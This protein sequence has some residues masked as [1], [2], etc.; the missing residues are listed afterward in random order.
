M[1]EGNNLFPLYDVSTSTEHTLD[2]RRHTQDLK[3][4]GDSLNARLGIMF[5]DLSKISGPLLRPIGSNT[6]PLWESCSP[7]GE[8]PARVA[9]ETICHLEV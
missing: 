1:R 2:T 9:S 3:P 7:S 8:S 4:G 6:L 5:S